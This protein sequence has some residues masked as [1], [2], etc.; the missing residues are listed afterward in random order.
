MLVSA[1]AGVWKTKTSDPFNFS[2]H[3][4]S[5]VVFQKGTKIH[6]IDAKEIINK[7]REKHSIERKGTKDVVYFPEG[8]LHIKKN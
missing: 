4:N 2:S 7:S 1:G 3:G 8:I 6:L 5:R